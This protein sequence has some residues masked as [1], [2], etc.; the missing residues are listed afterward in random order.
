MSHRA[1]QQA[2]TPCT[3]L[4]SRPFIIIPTFLGTENDIPIS[5]GNS[6]RI[7]C[8]EETQEARLCPSM[9]P[10]G[11][12]DVS[13]PSLSLFIEASG[14]WREQTKRAQPGTGILQCDSSAEKLN[15][16]LRLSLTQYLWLRPASPP[17]ILSL[18]LPGAGLLAFLPPACFL[19]SS[20]ILAMPVSCLGPPL[21]L[22]SSSLVLPLLHSSLGLV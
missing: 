21:F 4:S 17:P 6:Y 19:Y 20:A 15:L 7:R 10:R 2:T 9:A 11:A 1:A 3:P 12:R 16:K 22:S 14:P 5:A 18:S 8:C 13:T